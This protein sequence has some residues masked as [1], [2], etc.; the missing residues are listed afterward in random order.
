VLGGVR[1]G[2]SAHAERL[3]RA[4]AG[5][6]AVLATAQ[7]GDG[8]MAQ[9]IAQHKA[10][11][12]ANWTI[13]EEPLALAAA[14]T[15]ICRDD[16]L[17]VVDCLTLWLTNLLTHP[18]PERLAQERGALLAGLPRLPG[19]IVLVANETGM[20]IV[21]MGELTRRYV[22]E[23]GRLHQSLAALCDRVTLVVAGLPHRLKGEAE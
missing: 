19:R 5:P 11:R 1:S 13:I 8:E 14:L 10:Q 2:K 17:V 6:V 16:G 3:A 23:S 7:A 15:G 21:P 22:D 9:R 20:G 12:P 18:D 4:H